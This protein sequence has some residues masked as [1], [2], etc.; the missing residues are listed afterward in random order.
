MT[1]RTGAR[2]PSLQLI[3]SGRACSIRGVAW[4]EWMMFS[5]SPVSPLSL[6]Y[7]YCSFESSTAGALSICAV[8]SWRIQ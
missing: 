3:P 6:S 5:V 8:C 7:L 2:S 1:G 4:R